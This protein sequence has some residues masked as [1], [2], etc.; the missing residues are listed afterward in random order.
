MI[1]SMCNTPEE[2]KKFLIKKFDYWRVELHEN[3]CYLGRTI[4]ILK[5]HAEDLSEIN[6]KE[7]DELFS[8][9]KSLKKI[10]QNVFNPDVINYASLGNKTRHLHLHII[11]RY[12]RQIEFAG[13]LFMD[14]RWGNN[15]FPYEK[16]FNITDNVYSQI[17]NV[18][19]PGL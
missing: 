13:T 4:I 14:K 18:I 15:P 1:C 9:I 10:L 8:I 11:P 17:I 19:F 3:Q 6:S 12:Q 5:R 2:Y 7:K 16:D